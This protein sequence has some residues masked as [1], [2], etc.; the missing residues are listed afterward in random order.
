MTKSIIITKRVGNLLS[1]FNKNFNYSH[2]YGFSPEN[3]EIKGFPTRYV[4]VS[5]R[6]EE[7]LKENGRK[8]I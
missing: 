3:P 1:F 7:L 4:Y 6:L 5:D 8:R 2:K